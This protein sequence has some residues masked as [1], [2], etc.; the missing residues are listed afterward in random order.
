MRSGAERLASNFT[1]K[2]KS[3]EEQQFFIGNGYWNPYLEL[4]HSRDSNWRVGP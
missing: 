3:V 2:S 1:Q 4:G